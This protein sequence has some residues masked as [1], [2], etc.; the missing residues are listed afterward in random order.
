MKD[1][2]RELCPELGPWQVEL[3]AE[4]FG[5]LNEKVIMYETLL[6]KIQLHADVTMNGV[7]LGQLIRNICDWSY[8]HRVG[9]GQYS[10]EEREEII[11]AAFD[12]LLEIK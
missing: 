3:I 12:K 4:E 1:W 7:K 6:H 9:N 10:D 11:K 2:L 8:A 5:S